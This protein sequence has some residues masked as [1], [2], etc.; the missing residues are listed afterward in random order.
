MTEL[1][2]KPG[3]SRSVGL[4]NDITFEPTGRTYIL[5]VN[6]IF[7]YFF[8]VNNMRRWEDIIRIDLKE[9]GINTNNWVDSA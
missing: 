5:P 7:Y 4:Y 3:T 6:A 8:A 1:G 2:I 9:I